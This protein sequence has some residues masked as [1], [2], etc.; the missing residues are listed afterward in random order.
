MDNM[1][2]AVLDLCSKHLGEF[3]IRNGQAVVRVC[4]FCHGGNNHDTNTFAV[5]LYNGMFN[6]KRGGC[7]KEGT[8]RELCDYFGEK[9]MENISMP[10]PIGAVRKTYERPDP[11][12]LQPLTE[13]AITYMAT[14]HISE[15]TLNRFHV[16]CDASGNLV[17]PLYRDGVLIS[18]KYRKPKKHTKADGPKEWQN[19]NAEQILFGMDA[20]SF[21]KPLIITE[22][23]IDALSLYEAGVHNV[24]SVPCGCNN[25]DWIPNCWDWLE[26]F[27]QIILFGDSDQPGLEMMSTLMKR[28]GEDRC[29]LP[30]EYPELV[31]N[32]TDYNRP[33][34]DAN[35]ILYAYGEEALKS[36]VDSCEPAPIKGM[37]N[38]ASVPFI[39]PSSV[40]RI[41]TRIPAVDAAIGGLGEGGLTIISGKRGEGKSTIS[42]E[43]LL[44]A[45]DQG[46]SVAAYS[47]ELSA[48][49]FLEWILAQACE[50]KYITV[51]TDP[52]SGKRYTAVPNEIQQRIKSWI[53]GKFFLFDNA[54]IN[55]TS[56]IDSIIS[57]F[58]VCAKRFGCKLFLVDNLM[59]LTSGVEEEIKM[60]AKI[61][62]ALKTFATKFKVHVILV[63][64]PRKTQPGQKF[65]NDDVAGNSAITN[66]A[67]LVISIEKP[68]IRITKNREF[69]ETPYIECGFDPANR[70]IFQK[71]TGD[72]TVYGWDHTGISIP[73]D[74]ACTM[75]EFQI[76]YKQAEQQ[77]QSRYPF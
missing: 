33:C 44:N 16:S 73:E 31:L 37:L 3:R 71:S 56:L 13:E 45:I 28:L 27:Q 51:H 77:P 49:K 40:P 48:Y 7:N 25:M 57:V 46:H 67:D 26:H 8:F 59:M 36:I 66:L 30:G 11:A 50:S 54:Y 21:N 39:D 62:A 18:V 29:M 55:E 52:R 5:G 47:G 70:R 6:C 23:E 22:G 58:S 19:K 2:S 63:S 17:F 12:I 38:L 75:P 1:M 4:P 15:E 64:H 9:H 53:D 32:G 41:Y 65:T 20:V 14:R 35:E 68:D 42:G 34:K 61:V 10:K 24:V 72:R 43:F 60:Q 69:G 76:Q 74:Q